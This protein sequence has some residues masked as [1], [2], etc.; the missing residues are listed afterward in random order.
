[1]KATS[2]SGPVRA[3]Y[4]GAITD[5]CR[6]QFR[7]VY[8]VVNWS[9]ALAITT[10]GERVEPGDRV[11][12]RIDP[13]RCGTLTRNR[14]EQAGRVYWQIHFPDGYNFHP[15]DQLISADQPRDPLELLRQGQLGR[16]AD[17]RKLLT[18]VR[19]NGRLANVIYSMETTNT[20]FYAYQFKPV[21]KFLNTPAKGLLIA[22]EVGLGK[23]IEAGLIW[24]ELRSRLDYRRLLVLCPAVLREKWRTELARRF[25]IK[26][27]LMDAKE[28]LRHF[29]DPTSISP[30]NEFAAI[31]TMSGL[32]PRRGWNDSENPPSHSASKLAMLLDDKENEEPLIDLLVIDEAHYLRNPGTLTN[33]L[34]RLL[35][36]ISDRVVMLSATPVHL[37]SQDLFQLLVLADQDTF[38]D[39]DAF[40]SVLN[41]NEP[42][43]RARDAL[44]NKDLT[45]AAFQE[46][47]RKAQVNSF[48]KDSRQL[49]ALIDRAVTDSELADADKRSELAFRLDQ[50][51]LLGN[52]VSRTRKREVQEWRVLREAVPEKVLMN[53]LEADLYDRV[54]MA[55]REFAKRFAGHEGFLL[56]TPQ[57]QLSSCMPAAIR[58]WRTKNSAV[59]DTSEE[60]FG[61]ETDQEPELSVAGEIVRTLGPLP[62]FEALRDHDSKFTVLADRL[63]RFLAEHPNEKVVIFSYFL[64]TLDYLCERL[65][66]LGISGL[67]LSGD[68]NLDKADILRRFQDSSS[69]RVLISSEVGSEGVDLQFCRV[70]INYDLPWNP[71]RLEQRIGRLDR[72]G[73]KASKIVIWNLMYDKTID[74]RIYDRLYQRLQLFERTL[75]GLEAML[76]GE[77]R[78][79]T[80]DLLLGALTPQQEETRI[81][82]TAQ[83]L[84]NLRQEEERLEDEAPSLVAYGDY[85]LNQI[86][87]ARELNR[88]ISGE[89]IRN[90]VVDFFREHYVGCRFDQRPTTEYALTYEISLT[91]DAKYEL[92]DFLTKTGIIGKTALTNASSSPIRCI[93]ENKMVVSGSARSEVISQIHPLVRFVG[94]SLADKW[95]GQFPPIA[96][97]VVRSDLPQ[98]IPAGVYGFLMQRW[99]V[100]GVQE[101][102]V[103]FTTCMR[104]SPEQ[105]QLGDDTSEQILLAAANRGAD[106]P[107]ARGVLDLE[108]AAHVIGDFCTPHAEAKHAEFV[109][110]VSDENSDRANLQRQSVE[111]HYHRQ[112][113]IK[114]RVREQHVRNGRNNLVAATDGQIRKLKGF[115]E[116]RLRKIADGVIPRSR[117]DE[118]CIGVILAEH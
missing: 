102:E 53:A 54:T 40:D 5:G 71:M 60:D 101:K 6:G 46:L 76:G 84:V 29:S 94:A 79:L 64:A 61:I 74:A 117:C 49:Q 73:Q 17:L 87:A 72:L 96:V 88:W 28:L 42:L 11:C 39:L 2:G 26:A 69:L 30:Q 25:G 36:G 104:L 47:L 35:S 48:L 65:A 19:L 107:E 33:E 78:K 4:F 55:V 66:E 111:R 92:S 77:I 50:T 100:A 10:E 67:V 14:R 85:I 13:N 9:R 89:D 22:D 27:Q 18:H 62:T 82:Q 91:N 24:T 37:R 106:W 98:G 83:A 70:V 1:M 12:L 93:F 20:D 16:S 56:V 58:A 45:A 86:K 38:N 68:P 63:T 99:A 3:A 81:E 59:M 118:V 115:T 113:E 41:A 34:G 57:R 75:G 44:I 7:R 97:R 112:L 31:C 110:Q 43:V 108:H 103:L 116:M 51:N 90:Y 15:E 52:V 109:R 114:E 105:L 95:N 80:T 8:I 23:T 21:L 32:R